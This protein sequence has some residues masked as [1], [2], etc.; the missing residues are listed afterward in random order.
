MISKEGDIKHIKNMLMSDK[1]IAKKYTKP[2][3]KNDIIE[4][5]V[6]GKSIYYSEEWQIIK[7][8]IKYFDRKLTLMYSLY[9]Q[10]V[11]S[12]VNYQL[13]E[14]DNILEKL[15]IFFVEDI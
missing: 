14:N 7:F 13:D 3:I 6:K 1:L 4:I 12:Q 8:F 10:G 15:K 5:S 11:Y 2:I 9:D